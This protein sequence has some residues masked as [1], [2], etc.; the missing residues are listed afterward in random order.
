MASAVGVGG[1][2]GAA[3][4]LGVVAAAAVLLVARCVCV[5]D[6][7]LGCEVDEGRGIFGSCVVRATTSWV[8]PRGVDH[9]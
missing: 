5:C 2:A 9:A 6:V 7:R 4:A 8:P 1:A 3:G